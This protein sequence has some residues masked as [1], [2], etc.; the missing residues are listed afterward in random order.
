M[1]KLS[2]VFALFVVGVSSCVHYE[3]G[4]TIPIKGNGNIITSEETVS[5]FENVE[6]RVAADVNY[7]TSSEYRVVVTVDSNLLEYVVINTKGKTLHIGVGNG[8]YSFTKFVVDIYCPYVAKVSIHGSGNFT[9][10]DKIV[11]PAFKSDIS[12]SGD[13]Q[14]IFECEDFS[15]HI[16][17]SGEMNGE[18]KCND[19]SASIVGSGTMT[20]NGNGKNA[21]I[22]ITGS[23]NF[24]GKE[25]KTNNSDVSVTGSGDVYIWVVDNLKANLSGSGDI[26]Y[27]GTP[28]IDFGSSGSGRIKSEK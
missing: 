4:F 1:R 13:I 19:F 9:T 3:N 12:G 8:G 5:L 11:V 2:L 23:G 22:K 16:S 28:K 21:N 17:G 7:H 10:I 6:V 27:R 15:A 25:F 14:G 26:I 20:I 24:N 18:V